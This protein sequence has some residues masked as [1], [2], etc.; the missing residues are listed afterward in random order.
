MAERSSCSPSPGAISSPLTAE[1]RRRKD[2][3]SQEEM[4]CLAQLYQEHKSTIKADFSVVN[5]RGKAAAWEDITRR[6][7]ES[8]PRG[9]TTKD[10]QKKWQSIQANA[11][12]NISAQKQDPTATGGGLAPPPLSQLDNL[13]ADILGSNTVVIGGCHDRPNDE[14]PTFPLATVG[15]ED[16]RKVL[17]PTHLRH[18]TA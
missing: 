8:F 13:V 5:A 17:N 12:I 9:R 4:L 6:L 16:E 1:Q 11:K 14:P 2:N 15:Y 3:W 18:V 7:T 10:C